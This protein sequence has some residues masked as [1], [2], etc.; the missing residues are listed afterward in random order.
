[1]K[2]DPGI[3][4]R[5]SVRLPT[6]D[7]AE[8]GLYFVTICVSKRERV[9]GRIHDGVLI[10]SAAGRIIHRIWQAIP[11]RFPTV[12]LDAFV[13]MPDHV[14]GIVVLR[15][16]PTRPVTTAESATRPVITAESAT[17]PVTTAGS[18]T[19]PVTTAESA[20]RP[21]TTAGSATRP[22]TTAGSATRPVTTAE[23]ATAPG[24]PAR[25]AASSAPAL[26]TVIR[27]FKSESAVLVNRLLGRSGRPLWQRNYHERVIRRGELER[28]RRYI[29]QNPAKWTRDRRHQPDQVRWLVEWDAPDFPDPPDLL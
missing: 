20:T 28:I 9:F 24:T 2:F 14:H 18:V 8:A 16:R 27:A 10:P 5:R 7:Y 21:V 15:P 12:E 23:S 19:R 11:R 22:V 26:G 3:H 1:M 4:H 29:A 6:R 13:V 17:R 25:G